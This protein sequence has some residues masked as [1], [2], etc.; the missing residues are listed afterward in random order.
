M[1]ALEEASV[2]QNIEPLATFVGQLVAARTAEG[3]RRAPG[4]GG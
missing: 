2:R 1:A 3:T 4:A